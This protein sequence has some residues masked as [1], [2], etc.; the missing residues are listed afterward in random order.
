MEEAIKEAEKA[1][2]A[3]EVPV[4]AVI[5]D[6]KTGDIIAKAGNLSEENK[7]PTQHAEIIAIKEACKKLGQSRLTGYDIYVTLEPCPMCAQAISFARLD[8]LYYGAEDKKGGGVENGAKIYSA[9]S[10][11]HK[12]DVYSGIYQ[13]DAKELLQRF[14]KQKRG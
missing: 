6:K 5:V 9:S 8:S 14:F 1:F 10:C 11:H 4:G 12:P 3:D 7:D 13:K 2:K